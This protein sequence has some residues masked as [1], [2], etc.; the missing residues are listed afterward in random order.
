[1]DTF[2]DKLAQKFTA[3]EMIKANMAAEAR[4][5]RKL[6]DQVESYEAII[7]EM[8]QLTLKN[9]ETAERIAA[10]EVLVQEMKQLNLKNMEAVE[11]M[12]SFAENANSLT[13][14]V[15][16]IAESGCKSIQ[17]A[18]EDLQQSPQIDTQFIEDLFAKTDE[19]MH[20]ENVK[21]YRNVQAVVNDGLKEQ[22]E[23]LLRQG[24]NAKGERSF[25]KIMNIITLVAVFIDIVLHVLGFFNIF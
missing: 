15:N 3:Q 8:R 1:M 16:K 9:M 18:V 25:L 23:T 2:M 12:N 11:R 14:Q 24:D 7:Q 20:S 5:N 17:K 4:E 21:V 13:Q 22:T 10:Y 6:R 19:T